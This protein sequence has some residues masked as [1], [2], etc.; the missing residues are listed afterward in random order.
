VTSKT[1]SATAIP[2]P[3]R[4]RPSTDR[5]KQTDEDL[6]AMWLRHLNETFSK[7]N[8]KKKYKTIIYCFFLSVL[9]F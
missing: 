7:P 2:V 4:M 6:L 1:T 5:N 3:R 9:D 8:K